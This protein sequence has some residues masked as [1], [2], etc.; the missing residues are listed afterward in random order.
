IAE[1]V[2]KYREFYKVATQDINEIKNFMHE[3]LL[4]SD[5][6]IFIAIN[7]NTGNLIGFIQLYPLFSTVSLRKQWM[8]NDFYVLEAERKKGIGTM[9]INT[10]FEYFKD[11]AKGCILVTDKTNIVAKEFYTKLGWKTDTYDFYT[12]YF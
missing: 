4:N 12:Y 3:R 6:K 11:K 9:L 10:V 2:K 1:I 5:S 8:L 7:E